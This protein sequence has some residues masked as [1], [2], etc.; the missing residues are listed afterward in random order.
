MRETGEES[1]DEV[2]CG[3]VCFLKGKGNRRGEVR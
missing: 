1:R 2:R 3:E